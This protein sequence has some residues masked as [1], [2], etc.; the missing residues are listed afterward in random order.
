MLAGMADTAAKVRRVT[1]HL[2]ELSAKMRQLDATPTAQ[3]ERKVIEL[4]RQA[5]ASIP[6]SREAGAF[7]DFP[8]QDQDSPP[9]LGQFI[10]RHLASSAGGATAGAGAKAGGFGLSGVAGGLLA[11]LFAA[12]LY[13]RYRSVERMFER[14]PPPPLPL[15]P[16]KPV[17]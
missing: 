9:G 3:A 10:A 7:A 14:T 1:A 11:A 2:R 4:L 6:L 15:R 5:S 8:E 12:V 17:K 16:A 13:E